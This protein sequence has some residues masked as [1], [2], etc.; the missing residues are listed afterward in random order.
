MPPAW[1]AGRQRGRA[2]TD[3]NQNASASHYSHKC[4]RRYGDRNGSIRRYRGG[5][6]YGGVTATPI[7]TDTPTVTATA[8][9]TDTPVPPTE[10]PAPP[11][12][13][14][15]PVPVQ[16]TDTPPSTGATHQ[17][18]GTGSCGPLCQ[19]PGRWLQVQAPQWACVRCQRRRRTQAASALH[20]QRR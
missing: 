20:P 11:T 6:C 16:P 4:G 14:S 18:P 19:H 3:P 7:P 10:T 15:A 2:F 9:I 5:A 13:T 17:H 1:T 12:A 8:V